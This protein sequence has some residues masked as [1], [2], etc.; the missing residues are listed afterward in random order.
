V[1][2]ETMKLGLLVE[3]AETHQKLSAALLEKLRQHTLG[4]DAVV[5]EQIR[6][7]LVEQLHDMHAETERAVD[8]LRRIQRAANLRVTFWSI[9]I[10]GMC[11]AVA[12]A[13]A[14]W[15]LPSPE[16]MR[17]LR[18]QRDEL[19][20]GVERLNKLGG[21]ADLQHCGDERRLCVRVDPQAGHYGQ[22]SDYYVIKGY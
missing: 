7:T 14:W 10:T 3:T 16:E 11:A 4:L 9:G 18:E 1:D 15:W 5:R 6:R 2:E 12:V 19:V 13:V 20:A 22:H 17:G 21:R 8:S